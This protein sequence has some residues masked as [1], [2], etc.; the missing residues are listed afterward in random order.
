[1]FDLLRSFY[2]AAEATS[3]DVGSENDYLLHRIALGVPEGST[4]IIPMNAFPM[5]S[6]IDIMGGRASF[7][8]I[9]TATI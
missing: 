3:H 2:L 9:F 6:N 8:P 4:D 7:C 1:M 5:E